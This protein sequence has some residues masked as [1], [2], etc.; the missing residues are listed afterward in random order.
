[1][2]QEALEIGRWT[3]TRTS[4]FRQPLAWEVP[5]NA[6]AGEPAFILGGGPSLLHADVAALR[7][8][9]R[10][11]ACNNA[12]EIA[13]WADILIFADS[14]WHK[15]NK[16]RLDR[17]EG[18]LILTRA[19]RLDGIRS[20]EQELLKTY[21]DTRLRRIA[22]DKENALSHDPAALAGE[23]C[24]SMALNLAWLYGCDP[25][26]L[27]GIDM[28]AEG[29][30]HTRHPVK[31]ESRTYS[32]RMRPAFERM[33]AEI[34]DRGNRA[35][36]CNPDSAMRALPF[37]DIEEILKM[38]DIAEVERRKY[39]FVWQGDKYRKRSPGWDGRVEAWRELGCKQGE[40]LIDY[41]CG[42]GRATA[43]F[44]RRGLRVT[45]VDIAANA[46]ETD[47]PFVQA[48][49]WKLPEDLA[50]ADYGFSCDV[51][52]HLPTARIDQSIAMIAARTKQAAWLRIATRPDKNGLKL[53][54]K[55]LHLTVR[56]A[57]WWRQKL[58]EHFRIVDITHC[59]ENGREVTLLC[60]HSPAA[61]EAA[62]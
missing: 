40:S 17:F 59:C 8:R 18:D 31:A 29:N 24:G 46:L 5:K 30:W 1:M 62:E 22:R 27:L 13:P 3:K 2:D 45:G 58:E 43:W 57:E 42:S 36:N 19:K 28:R 23:C 7:G 44:K 41:G 34:I 35:F 21:K 47:V 11:I 10:V 50:P 20:D 60:R 14:R 15:W 39:E 26:F 56:S 25:I 4:L 55:H 38:D 52:E 33:A 37:C 53:I 61:P 6:W 9:G 51:L 49:L 48:S 16:H 54:G 12:F 32:H